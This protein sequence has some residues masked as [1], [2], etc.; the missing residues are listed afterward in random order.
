LSGKLLT[1]TASP[2]TAIVALA[3]DMIFAARIR[4]AAK[5]AGVP[6]RVLTSADT[7]ADSIRQGAARLL[8]DL[9]FRSADPITLIERLRADPETAG[10]EILAFVSHV[11]DDRIAAARSAGA[12]RVMARSAFMRELPRLL[13]AARP[14]DGSG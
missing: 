7:V 6:V 14:A 5:A 4:G 9:D 10:V 2:P 12:T 8:L 11:R 3:A 1:D 13:A